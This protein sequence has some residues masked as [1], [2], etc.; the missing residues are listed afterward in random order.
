MTSLLVFDYDGVLVDSYNIFMSAFI[1]A[2]KDAGYMLLAPEEEFVKLL[3]EN[4]YQSMQAQGMTKDIIL[5]IALKV[6][7][8][9]L[10]NQ[11]QL[12]VFPGMQE[13]VRALSANH[14]LAVVTS[15]ETEVVRQ[16]L[17]ALNLDYF[18]KII[19]S[20]MEPSKTKSLIH[21]KKNYEG[22]MAYYIGDT[23]GDVKE[24]KKAAVHTVS[25]SWG[26]HGKRVADAMPDY[27]VSQPF[28][29]V[30]LFNDYPPAQQR[31]KHL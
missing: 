16:S 12:Q 27:V 29:L 25:V 2:C 8:H 19:G 5:S 21:L 28:E 26:W 31:D 13:A 30:S 9:T 17:A 6:K 11:E 10:A 14:H 1:D 24:G 20:D 22:L 15:N 18:E 7:E 3:D 4:L 23:I